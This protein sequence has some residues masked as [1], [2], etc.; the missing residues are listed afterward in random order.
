LKTKIR[1]YIPDDWESVMAIYAN[2]IKTGNATFETT[3]PSQDKWENAHVES[4]RLVA[5]SDRKIIAWAA[6][7]PVSEREAYHGAAEVSVYV[8]RLHSGKGIGKEIL[9]E[10]IKQSE[11]S[12]LWTLQASIFPENLASI[13]LHESCGFRVVGYR[14]KIGKLN[15]SWRDTIIMERRSK[16]TGI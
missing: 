7:S 16:I 4:C 5:V 1:K 8:D 14:E 3:L 11:A 15:G 9:S 12:G 6:L 13:R 2:G 10:L